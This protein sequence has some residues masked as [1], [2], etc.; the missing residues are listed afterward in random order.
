M[1]SS[2]LFQRPVKSFL[3][4]KVVPVLYPKQREQKE[5]SVEKF[6]DSREKPTDRTDCPWNRKT[7]CMVD[8]KRCEPSLCHSILDSQHEVKH[9]IF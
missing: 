8:G 1:N 2:K 5:K 4:S 6:Q 9:Q 7:K 3:A